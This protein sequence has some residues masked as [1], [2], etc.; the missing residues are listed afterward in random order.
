MR[1]IYGQDFTVMTSN[2]TIKVI[3]FLYLFEGVIMIE[4]LIMGG[5]HKSAIT[6]IILKK[7]HFLCL[8]VVDA[9]LSRTSKYQ[10]YLSNQLGSI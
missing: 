2:K 5:P 3:I 9:L 10:S 7:W 1:V 4:S 8:L 6:L